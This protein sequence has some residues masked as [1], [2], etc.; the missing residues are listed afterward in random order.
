[1]RLF[2]GGTLVRV[3][4]IYVASGVTDAFGQVVVYLTDNGNDAGVDRFS[5]YSHIICR[6]N[7]STALYAISWARS[8]HTLT[9]TVNEVTVVAGVLTFTPAVG[10][11]VGIHVE[12]GNH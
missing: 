9:V 12:G 2:Q 8:G 6:V 10:V 1:M 5:E 11:T 3:P 7:S 4:R